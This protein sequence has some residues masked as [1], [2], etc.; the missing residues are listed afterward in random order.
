MIWGVLDVDLNKVRGSGVDP[1]KIND[2]NIKFT[3]DSM[4]HRL[5]YNDIL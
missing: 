5:Y 1:K 3:Q 2:S 4:W